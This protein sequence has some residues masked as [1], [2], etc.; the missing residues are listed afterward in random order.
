MVL[1]LH[2]FASSPESSKAIRITEA[3]K[4]LGLRTHIPD[5]NQPSFRALTVSR[6][7]AQA[8]ALLDAERAEQAVLIGSSLGGFVALHTAAADAR[9]KG[10]VLLAPAFDFGAD[11]EGK[12]GDV[13]IADWQASG[14]AEVM[15]YAWE[16]RELVDWA[17]YEDARRYD[18]FAVDLKIPVLIFQGTED[19]VVDPETVK[20]WAVG[21]KNVRLELVP[22]DHQLQRSVDRIADETLAFVAARR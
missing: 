7:I 11:A 17:L 10:L 4:P 12:L 20:R 19:T 1:Y 21:R 22:D 6:M 18:A 9:V 15:H 2:G 14:S 16:R 3:L 5:L 8:R 13:S